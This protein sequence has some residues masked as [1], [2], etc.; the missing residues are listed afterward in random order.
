MECHR[1]CCCDHVR[2]GCIGIAYAT[3]DSDDQPVTITVAAE[4]IL[5]AREGIGLRRSDRFANATLRD[6]RVT[7]SI[8]VGPGDK[9]TVVP[10]D[11]TGVLVKATVVRPI[12]REFVSLR[13]G[14]ATGVP[15]T[16]TV[17][18]TID[19]I[20][21]SAA[22]VNLNNGKIQVWVETTSDSG[23]ADVL[24]DVVGYTIGHTH[25]DR[26]YTEAEVG[27]LLAAEIDAYSLWV[28]VKSDGS[29]AQGSAKVVGA[30]GLFE[31]QYEVISTVT[32]AI[33]P[34]SY[35]AEPT[36]RKFALQ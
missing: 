33:A 32:S 18:F 14:G 24:V 22:N 20:E 19:S 13:P 25:A 36:L 26:H 7:G 27:A 12:D 28:V 4:R 8:P 29:L 5:D 1:R 21:P 10:A 30:L 35:L 17:N 23:A 2:A 9:K 11:A 6:H 31:G 16:S 15:T 34:A 3:I